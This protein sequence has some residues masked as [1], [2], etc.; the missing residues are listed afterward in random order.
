M[1]KPDIDVLTLTASEAQKLLTSGMITSV[2]LIEAYLTQIERHNHSGLHLN[3]LISVAPRDALLDR[4][5]HLDF[6]RQAGRTLGALHGIPF[7]TKD[8]F[9]THP[10]M[11]MPTTAGAPCFR[12]AKAKRTAPLLQHL[13][14][15]HGMILLGK[16]NLTEFCG[17]KMPMLTPGW[18]AAGGQTQNPYIFGG[19]VKGEKILGH[20]SPGGSSSGSAVGVAAGFAPLSIGTEVCGSLITPANRAGVY[21]LKCGLG[22]VDDRGSWK[23]TDCIDHVGA[24]A[25]GAEDLAAFTA[26]LMQRPRPFEVGGG[27]E[28]MK[29]AFTDPKIWRLSADY[30][31]WPGDTRQQME[32]GF[33]EVVSKIRELGADVSENVELSPA[34]HL[35]KHEG[36][37]VFY[38]ISF[39]Q[40]KKTY[41]QNFIAEFSECE[42]Q[43]LEDI[44]KYNEVHKD[45]CLPPGKISQPKGWDG[46]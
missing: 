34:E 3:A 9:V 21:A 17:L 42:V 6:E 35:F 33:A 32:R 1:T 31:D 16:A 29:V 40:I 36:K 18:S 44:I 20:S 45:E 25:K 8:V 15:N 26:A 4:A 27:F 11:G 5:R 41:I 46:N 24:M 37:S 30:S 38:E 10:S 39:Y 43:C 23:Y 2:D 14:D 19:L 13:M 28:G 22:E 7:I 12:S